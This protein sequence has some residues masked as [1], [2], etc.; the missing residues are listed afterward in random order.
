MIDIE[1]LYKWDHRFL[2]L[3][4]CVSSWSKDPS[5]KVGAIIVRPDR[6]IASTGYNGFARGVWDIEDRLNDRDTRLHYTIHAELNAILTAH[7]PV[8]GY[9]LYCTLPPCAACAG[10]IVQSGITSIVIPK[11][12]PYNAKSFS[13]RWRA[14]FNASRI[15]CEEAGVSLRFV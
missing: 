5:T 14:S 9:T 6:T 10:A 2:G 8:K 15:I 3:A 1:D 13:D 11:D 7:E 4:R 12:G